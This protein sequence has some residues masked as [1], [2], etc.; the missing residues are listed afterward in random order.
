MAD[1]N[2]AYGEYIADPAGHESEFFTYCTQTAQARLRG[3]LG[4]DTE[5]VAQEIAIK[6]F[7]VL[8]KF[9]PSKGDFATYFAV[10][11]RSVRNDHLRKV[12]SESR[13]FDT[14]LALGLLFGR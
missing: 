1:L 6:L 7:R 10:V 3:A 5:D 4:N 8:D 13:V 2:R 14:H 9:D 12:Q 11:M